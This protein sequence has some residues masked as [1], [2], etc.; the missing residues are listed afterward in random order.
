M[1]LLALSLFFAL[2]ACGGIETNL[3]CEGCFEVQ[4]VRIIGVDTLDTSKGHIRLFDG[5]ISWACLP[6]RW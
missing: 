4:V 3:T 1:R 5:L 6:Y 2:A